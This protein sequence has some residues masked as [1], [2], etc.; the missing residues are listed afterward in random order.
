MNCSSSDDEKGDEVTS[1][2]REYRQKRI[3]KPANSSAY[4]SPT[5]HEAHQVTADLVQTTDTAVGNTANVSSGVNQNFSAMS[6]ANQSSRRRSTESTLSRLRKVRKTSSSSSVPE[7]RQ[8]FKGFVFFFTPNDDVSPARR[9]RIQRSVEFGAR[10][11]TEWCTGITHVIVD[12]GL[13]LADVVKYLK[14]DAIP[15]TVLLVNEN[16]PVDCI[17]KGAILEGG[18]QRFQVQ[19]TAAPLE[20][21][22]PAN[23]KVVQPE[24]LQV[25][26]TQRQKTQ[27]TTSE[28]SQEG[29]TISAVVLAPS[30]DNQVGSEGP[31]T[32]HNDPLNEVIQTVK[33]TATLVG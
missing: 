17:S 3:L 30:S 16:Y 25:K 24:T 4:F 29:N 31:T 8:I 12:K 32:I 10:R 23:S 28:E 13:T 33:A 1:L 6:Q 27:G 7:S 11:A 14:V 26:S 19:G 5:Q 22:S 15:K 21:H 20:E 9:M 18:L 2:L